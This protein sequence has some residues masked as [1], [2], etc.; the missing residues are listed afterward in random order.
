MARACAFRILKR[1]R[2]PACGRGAPHRQL[3]SCAPLFSSQ[4]CSAASCTDSRPT[5]THASTAVSKPAHV[6]PVRGDEPLIYL[7]DVPPPPKE[8]SDDGPPGPPICPAVLW[9][10][11]GWD[12]K[13][14]TATVRVPE[15]FEVCRGVGFHVDGREMRGGHGYSAFPDDGCRL[16]SNDPYQKVVRIQLPERRLTA[17]NFPDGG[18]PWFCSARHRRLLITHD[19]VS[20]STAH[21]ASAITIIRTCDLQR[22][23]ACH[24]LRLTPT[25]RSLRWAAVPSADARYEA[26]QLTPCSSTAKPVAGVRIRDMN[27]GRIVGRMDTANQ[28]ASFVFHDT[29]VLMTSQI[30][31]AHPMTRVVNWRTG[32]LIWQHSGAAQGPLW[33]RPDD[34]AFAVQIGRIGGDGSD[35]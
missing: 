10:G 13:A 22:P 6:R 27:S 31:A 3:R 20:T 21:P 18:D 8:D 17:P 16:G 11:Y 9:R 25:P 24:D 4:R 29:A 12:G 2:V 34:R 35:V 23:V 33:L 28:V 7:T 26:E 15:T 14:T 32:A 5:A 30:G 1:G 19:E